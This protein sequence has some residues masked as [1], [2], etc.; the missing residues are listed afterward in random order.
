MNGGR[1]AA[2]PL[3]PSPSVDGALVSAGGESSSPPHMMGGGGLGGNSA[4]AAVIPPISHSGIHSSTALQ[5]TFRRARPMAVI[6]AGNALPSS[7]GRTS[8]TSD[9]PPL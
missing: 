4:V 2:S 6:Y 7:P 1:L 5:P 3:R 8:A 9:T